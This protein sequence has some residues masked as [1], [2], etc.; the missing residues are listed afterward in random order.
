MRMEPGK[1]M[2]AVDFSDF[3]PMIVSYGKSLA[4]EFDAKLYLCHIVPTL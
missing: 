3:T 2:C 1:I 4:S